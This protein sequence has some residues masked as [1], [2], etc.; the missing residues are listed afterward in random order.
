MDYDFQNI[1]ATLSERLANG[2]RQFIFTGKLKAGSK[3][4]QDELAEEFGVS[5]MPIRE[6]LVILSHEGLVM[7]EP[8]RGA[9][10]APLTLQ[11]VDESYAIRHFAEPEALKLSI[12]RLSSDDLEELKDALEELERA[13]SLGDGGAF[14][15]ANN[16]FHHLLR[17]RCPWPKLKSLVE[18]MWNG[19]PPLTPQFVANQMVLDREEHRELY[20]AATKH[21]GERAA[22]TMRRHIKRSWADARTHFQQLG[23]P[24][25][26]E[27]AG[28]TPALRNT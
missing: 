24:E 18:T 4:A 10:V 20:A 13:E 21:N 8:R 7:L 9:W 11:M 19:F 16:R 26:P 22:E 5:R 3:I 14:V 27:A 25:S 23:W 28:L 17:S 1:H 2:I 15:D 12:P 6:A